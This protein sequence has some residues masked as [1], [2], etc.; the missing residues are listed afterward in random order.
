MIAALISGPLFRAPE[1]RTAKS[2]RPFVT[3]TIKARDGDAFQFVRV[4][5]FSDTVQTEL[6]RLYDGDAITVQ[7]PLRVET[8]T[9]AD[10]E[11]KI[12]ISI[13]AENVLALRQPPKKR[14]A[15][16]PA[17]PDSR[18]K[19]E[20]QRGSWTGPDDGPLDEFPF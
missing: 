6:S 15:K 14:E 4:T 1:K 12:S 19:Q 16:S 5:A 8:Y 17:A 3:A 11:T 20:R 18:T 9:A 7:G 10:G 13:I 2:G